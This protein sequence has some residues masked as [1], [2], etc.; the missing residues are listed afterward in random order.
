MAGDFEPKA[1]LPKFSHFF[2]DLLDSDDAG[3]TGLMWL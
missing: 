3:E 2:K 1:L